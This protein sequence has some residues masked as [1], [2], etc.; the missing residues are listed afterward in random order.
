MTNGS[1]GFCLYDPDFTHTAGQKFV[2]ILD[3]G[4][5][6]IRSRFSVRQYQSILGQLLQHASEYNDA[7]NLTESLAVD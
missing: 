6:E 7:V 1:R 5:V 2:K 3:P 4:R